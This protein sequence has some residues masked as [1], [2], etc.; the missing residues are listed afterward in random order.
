VIGPDHLCAAGIADLGWPNEDID[1]QLVGRAPSRTEVERRI[2]M[3]ASVAANF[4]PRHCERGAVEFAV[5][6]AER[7]WLVSRPDNDFRAKGNADV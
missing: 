7:D 4:H 2:D 1:W 5:E 6:V 3:R